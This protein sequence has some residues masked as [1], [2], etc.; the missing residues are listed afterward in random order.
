MQVV[1]V[2]QITLL[3]LLWPEFIARQYFNAHGMLQDPH[4]NMILEFWIILICNSC[5][6]LHLPVQLLHKSVT[7][8][9]MSLVVVSSLLDQLLQILRV[10]FLRHFS[11]QHPIKIPAECNLYACIKALLGSLLIPQTRAWKLRHDI[12]VVCA[13]Q[14]LHCLCSDWR[15]A[16]ERFVDASLTSCGAL[17][18]GIPRNVPS[19]HLEEHLASAWKPCCLQVASR[20][21]NAYRLCRFTRKI[22][23]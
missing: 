13:S 18:R 17:V 19:F 16:P 15:H 9:K 6:Q 11:L 10:Y 7:K 3:K 4:P 1:T 12:V 23:G 14:R 22:S 20:Q 21:R 2:V 8:G 5:S